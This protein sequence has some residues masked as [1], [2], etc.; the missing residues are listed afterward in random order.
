MIKRQFCYLSA[1]AMQDRTSIFP[2]MKIFLIKRYI[3][4]QDIY[5][6][7]HVQVSFN[8]CTSKIIIIPEQKG[9][10]WQS[11]QEEELQHLE[12]FHADRFCCCHYNTS[13]ESK[14]YKTIKTFSQPPKRSNIN[15]VCI[16][17]HFHHTEKCYPI[18]RKQR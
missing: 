9:K 7:T 4:Q 18:I 3:T 10:T 13:K 6:L 5:H 12:I 15:T 11:H 17:I 14:I 8:T 2:Y 16:Y 1:T